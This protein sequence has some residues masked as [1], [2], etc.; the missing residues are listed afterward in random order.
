MAMAAA[1]LEEALRWGGGS[2]GDDNV[3]ARRAEEAG[4]LGSWAPAVHGSR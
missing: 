3:A 4:E 2:V 1:V